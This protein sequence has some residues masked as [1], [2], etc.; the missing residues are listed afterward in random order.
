MHPLA[1]DFSNLKDNE[2][3]DKITDLTNKYFMTH[4]PGV[5]SQ[6]SSLLE[7]YKEESSRRQRLT[8]EKMMAN[9]DKGLD[10]LI[11]IS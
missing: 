6:I 10:K 2:I 3:H 11:N 7:A 1:G 5:Q 4:N 9:R 8:M